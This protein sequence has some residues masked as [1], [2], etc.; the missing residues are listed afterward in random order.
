MCRA[1]LGYQTCA[2][3]LSICPVLSEQ[4]GATCFIML[5]DL[6]VLYTKGFLTLEELQS[7]YNFLSSQEDRVISPFNQHETVGIIIKE[8]TLICNRKIAGFSNTQ[9]ATEQISVKKAIY[10]Y[11]PRISHLTRF[12]HV[13]LFLPLKCCNRSLTWP[14]VKFDLSGAPE[15]SLNKIVMRPPSTYNEAQ[16]LSQIVK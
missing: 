8:L 2:L 4:A 3:C 13:A 10:S 6:D 1:D 16:M 12:D 7:L 5:H 11:V 9:T 15:N 14:G